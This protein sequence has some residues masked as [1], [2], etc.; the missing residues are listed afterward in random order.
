MKIYLDT[1]GCRLNQSEI[2]HMARQFRAAGQEIVASA[3]GA[4]LAVVNTCAVTNDAATDSRG[5]IRHLARLGVNEIIATG[6]WSTLQPKEASQLPNVLHVVPNDQ[7]DN[8]VPEILNLRPSTFNP[9]SSSFILH[10]S[11]FDIKRQPI[12]GLHHRTRAF[13]KVQDSTLRAGDV[14]LIAGTFAQPGV[15]IIFDNFVVLQP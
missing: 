7:K 3:E 9:R 14:G 6:C 11:S 13:I 8:L 1:L 12:P 5:K 10:N 15:D 2:E 4:E